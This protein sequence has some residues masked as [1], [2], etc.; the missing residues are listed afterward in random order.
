VLELVYGPTQAK[1]RISNEVTEMIINAIGQLAIA[2]VEIEK[3]KAA[4]EILKAFSLD[5]LLDVSTSQGIATLLLAAGADPSKAIEQILPLS[6]NWETLKDCLPNLENLLLP[7]EVAKE[8][9]F[10][11]ILTIE[12][13]FDTEINPKAETI[14]EVL[15]NANKLY[16]AFARI[17][18]EKEYQALTVA[19]ADSGSAVR[20]DFRGLGSIIKEVKH[21]LV[22]LWR[23]LRHRN[24]EDVQRKTEVLMSGVEAVSKIEEKRKKGL[25][26]EEDAARAKHQIMEAG[27]GLFEASA[28]PREIPR[29]E[30][31]SNQ[32][33]LHDVS[34]K[35][36][37]PA[38][39]I[40]NGELIEANEAE[41]DEVPVTDKVPAKPAKA[42]ST[43][44]ATKKPAKKQ[45]KKAA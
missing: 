6:S 41:A 7:S 42:K 24:I 45:S 5:K 35:L 29:I 19:Y 30:Q 18:G 36:L 26:S 21:F 43:K 11:E 14:A 28:L 44:K 20:F 22:D 40:V 39:P 27:L 25:L 12:L 10:D 33:L 9:D 37:P 34:R 2:R 1:E 17:Q 3:N 38:S 4:V 13:R 8:E 32:Q 31:V 15:F 23:A 16:E